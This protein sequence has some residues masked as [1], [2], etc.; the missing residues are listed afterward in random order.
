MRVRVCDRAA[1]AGL[2]VGHVI[3]SVDGSLAWGHKAT[4]KQIADTYVAKGQV[5]CVVQMRKLTEGN[6]LNQRIGEMPINIV[7]GE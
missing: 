3:Q 7:V 1:L 6:V 4:L 2:E 5:Q